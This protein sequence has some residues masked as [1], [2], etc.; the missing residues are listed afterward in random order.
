MLARPASLLVCAAF[1]VAGS[2]RAQAP[3][4]AAAELGKPTYEKACADC[5]GGKGRG[6]GAKARKLGFAPRDFTLGA[7]KC[8]CTPSGE[9]PTDEDLY[10][11]VTNGLPGTPM[12]PH[13]R[14]LSDDERRAVVHYLRT[15]A[16]M[17]VAREPP[18]CL[19]TSP[20]PAET[21]ELVAEGKL[22][23]RLMQCAKCHG[24]GGRGD[25]PAA[26]TLQDSWG[27]PIRPPDLGRAG[28]FKCGGELA[29]LYRTLRTGMT[30]SP[31]PSF[32]EAL[33][34]AR[35]DFSARSLT[36]LGSGA[37]L[38]E[39]QQYLARQPDAQAL[40]TLSP[41]AREALSSGRAWALS[42]YVR[43]LP[44]R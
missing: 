20:A 13:A 8:R 43:S 33:S 41:Q 19:A 27:K 10:R 30:G 24:D 35:E 17:R 34:F 44:R 4:S 36:A 26:R 7:F 18:A 11:T 25:G 23:Y 1:A 22:L 2:L 14:T 40:Q 37:E 6:D 31:M 29:D 28:V 39:L 12:T 21:P 32:D 42:A 3:P 15:L 16:P 38:S 9:P 5:H